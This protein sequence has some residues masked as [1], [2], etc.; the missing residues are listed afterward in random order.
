MP[1][2]DH[3][4]NRASWNA[5]TD[6]HNSHKGDQAKFLREGGSTLFQEELSRLEPLEGTTLLHLQ[7]NCGQDTLSLAARGATVTGVDISDRAIAF[8]NQLS[9]DAQIP[10]TFERGDVFDWLAQAKKDKR[11][12]DR[13]F[14]S[15]GA[16]GWLSCLDTWAQG[17]A[18]VLAPGGRFV[19][20]EFHPF[21]WW[22]VSDDGQKL[23]S[24]FGEK[25]VVEKEGV[26]DYVQ[27]SGSAL[28]PSGYQEGVQDFTNPEASVE[29]RFTLGDIITSLARAGLVIQELTEHP[30]CNGCK[31]SEGH[32]ESSPGVFTAGPNTADLPMMFSLVATKP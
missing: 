10:G 28:A 27:W 11:S 6:A 24:Y 29:Y 25:R 8:A 4:Q 1:H 30:H 9:Q 21:F 19:L 31:P 18:G 2:Q 32:I 3:E 14:S 5:V 13:V 26:P 15:Y 23:E 20:V 7:C 12:F 16:V 17:I 22:T